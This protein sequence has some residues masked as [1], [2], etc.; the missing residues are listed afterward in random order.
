MRALSIDRFS[1]IED[2]RLIQM[3]DP[4]VTPGEVLI[5]VV[6]SAIN[7]VDDKTRNGDIGD[8]TPPFPFTLGWELA[9][10]VVEDPTGRFRPGD[11][12]IGMSHQLG[13]GRG[14]WA[15]LVSLPVTE[16]AVAPTSVG[17]VEAGTVPLP[18]ATALQVLDWLD[19]HAD[20]RLLVTGAAGA[21]GSIAVQ[22]ASSTGIH[23]DAV[24]SRPSQIEYVSS[25]GAESVVT[26]VEELPARSYDRV[27]DT[28][29]ADASE[30]ISDGGR[31]ATVA[32]QAGPAPDLTARTIDSEL[33]QV[34][35]DGDV[36]RQLVGLVDSGV[37]SPRVDSV[38]SAADVVRAHQRF[39]AGNLQGKIALVF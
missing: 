36:L 7:P 4:E 34:R 5:R 2:L 38:F 19:I 33:C 21:V 10:I 25:L 31:Y 26:H 11:R 23:V 16:V 39:A 18:G 17:L 20:S 12:V 22:I 28:Y 15:D 35:A 8:S 1:P 9:G 3:P 30:A 32:T 14:T 6:S 24:V 27:F 13:T 29:G 37:I